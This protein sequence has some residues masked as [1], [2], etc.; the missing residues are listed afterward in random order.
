[1]T[2]YWDRCD[3]T[4]I[5]YENVVNILQVDKRFDIVAYDITV[6]G[7]TLP[8]RITLGVS[9]FLTLGY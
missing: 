7:N 8:T 4:R 5:V 6:M 9:D 2:L 1:M 3:N